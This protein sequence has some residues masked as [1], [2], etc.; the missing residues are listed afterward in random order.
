MSPSE[1]ITKETIKAAQALGETHDVDALMV[2]LGKQQKV[3]AEAP[4]LANDPTLDPPY[5]STHMGL[6]DDLREL[7]FRIVSLWSRKL[8]EVICGTE[9]DDINR[10]KLLDSLNISEAAAIAAVTSLL[11][12]F[13]SPAVAAPVAVIIVKQ[14]LVPA[15]EEICEF[16]GEKLDEVP[17]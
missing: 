5:D 6:I 2:L 10:K 8:H 12:P 4:D 7:G 11:L 13:I 17:K 15:G 16:W 1:Q 9:S 14:F 3:I